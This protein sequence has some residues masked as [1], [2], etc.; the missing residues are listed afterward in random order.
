M[1]RQRAE[2]V[3]A[4]GTPEQV[5]ETLIA[6]ALYDGEVD[7][8]EA[9]CLSFMRHPSDAVRLTAVL[10]LGHLARLHGALHL[11]LVLPLLDELYRWDPVLRGRIEDVRSDIGVFGER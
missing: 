8:T 5:S 4:T 11:D 10:C 9:Q 2:E 3:L 6:L 7:K 1:D